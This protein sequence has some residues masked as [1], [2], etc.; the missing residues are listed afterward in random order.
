MESKEQVDKLEVLQRKAN[1]LLQAISTL[2][3]LQETMLRDIQLA[4]YKALISEF[5]EVK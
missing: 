1:F 5:D 3:A 2:T 4:K